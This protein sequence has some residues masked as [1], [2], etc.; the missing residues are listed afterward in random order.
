MLLGFV[1]TGIA[2]GLL[3]LVLCWIITVGVFGVSRVVGFCVELMFICCDVCYG[4][5][6]SV[7]GGAFNSGVRLVAGC[8]SVFIVW[9]YGFFF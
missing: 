9:L 5:A 2:L 6:P 3:F 4:V 1:V 7:L 8:G